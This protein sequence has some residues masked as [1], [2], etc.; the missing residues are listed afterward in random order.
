MIRVP[1][2]HASVRRYAVA[3]EAGHDPTLGHWPAICAV[4]GVA[5]TDLRRRIDFGVDEVVYELRWLTEP[6]WVTLEVEIPTLV[7]MGSETG[8]HCEFRQAA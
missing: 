2:I 5:I 8:G 1:A 4:R 7:V 6:G 3:G